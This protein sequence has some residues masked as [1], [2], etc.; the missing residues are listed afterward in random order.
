M[1]GSLEECYVGSTSCIKMRKRGH[2]KIC[3]NPNLKDYNRDVYKF[4]RDNGDFENWE[5]YP[6][7]KVEFEDKIE[8]R[9]KERDW[10]EKLKPK[11]NM[12]K[13]YRSKEELKE[14]ESIRHRERQK[15]EN[16]VERNKAKCRKHYEENK[17]KY[18]EYSKKDITKIKKK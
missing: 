2:K 6:L 8:L 3:S 17:D 1:D 9:K 11:L 4:I 16:Y 10:I 7:E 5:L 13:S 14:Y 12:I 15:S 18:V